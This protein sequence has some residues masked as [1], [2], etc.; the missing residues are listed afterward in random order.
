MSAFIHAV[1]VENIYVRTAHHEIQTCDPFVQEGDH[2]TIHLLI[3][4]IET[5]F[6]ISAFNLYKVR[7]MSASMRAVCVEDFQI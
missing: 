3:F 6:D 7:S 2:K 1:C 4:V 5:S